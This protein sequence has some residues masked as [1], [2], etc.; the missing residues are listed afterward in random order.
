M[1]VTATQLLAGV[2][3]DLAIGVSH[4]LRAD[5]I[6]E[7]QDIRGLCFDKPVTDGPVPFPYNCSH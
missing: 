6:R 5:L 1:F 2:A 7:T 4:E 3:L